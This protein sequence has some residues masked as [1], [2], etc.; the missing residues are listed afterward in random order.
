MR[1]AAAVTASEAA[2]PFDEALPQ[3]PVRLAFPHRPRGKRAH[4]DDPPGR[5]TVVYVPP[6][7]LVLARVSLDPLRK[8]SPCAS[9]VDPHAGGEI[10]LSQRTNPDSPPRHYEHHLVDSGRGK[11]GLQP[12]YAQALAC[13]N[14]AVN[15]AKKMFI[16]RHVADIV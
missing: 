13:P 10:D 2:W 6:Q 16:S 4:C 15:L 11:R 3:T 12:L 8:R 7:F 1:I 14:P 5:Q 9:G